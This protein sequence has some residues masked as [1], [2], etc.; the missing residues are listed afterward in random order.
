MA[1]EPKQRTENASARPEPAERSAFAYGRAAVLAL[2]TL[3]ALTG[4]KKENAYVLPPPADVGVMHP[5]ERTFAPY[6]DST[7][8]VIA[9]NQVTL[10]AR[11]QGFVQQIAYEDGAHVDFSHPT[12]VY[13]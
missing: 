13:T 12:F 1:K 3:L 11:V 2:L 5:I 6:I 4:C 8:T 10:M 7:G 9:Y